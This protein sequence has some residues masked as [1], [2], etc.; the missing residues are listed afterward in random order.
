MTMQVLI[1][2][3]V[4]AI[5]AIKRFIVDLTYFA[6]DPRLTRAGAKA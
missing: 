5:F 6:L 1:S 3:T 2:L 4:A